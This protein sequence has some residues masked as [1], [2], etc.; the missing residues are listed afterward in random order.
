MSRQDS[1]TERKKKDVDLESQPALLRRPLTASSSHHRERE[2]MVPDRL[3][4]H[5]A[6]LPAL[7]QIPLQ[8][9]PPKPTMLYDVTHKCARTKELA[10]SKFG[11]EIS[12]SLSA[13]PS[14]NH[15]KIGPESDTPSPGKISCKTPVLF[16]MSSSFLPLNALHLPVLL[17]DM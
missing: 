15:G 3:R 17:P 14:R 1:V 5:S 16:L 11:A 13:S 9:S 8:Y 4:P 7:A 12:S 2:K 10:R 6:P